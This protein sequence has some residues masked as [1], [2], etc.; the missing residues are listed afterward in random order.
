MLRV[1][2][3]VTLGV[4]GRDSPEP[5]V[6]LRVYLALSKPGDGEAGRK[7]PS[8]PSGLGTREAREKDVWLVT[9]SVVNP[10]L[11]GLEEVLAGREGSP[12]TAA[13]PACLGGPCRPQDLAPASEKAAGL[14][15]E[16]HGFLEMHISTFVT[17]LSAN[18][19]GGQEARDGSSYSWWN[20]LLVKYEKCL[21]N[22][23]PAMVWKQMLDSS[24]FFFLF[25]PLTQF[26]K[27]RARIRQTG[28]LEAQLLTC[29][30][31]P[32]MT[33]R[34]R[35]PLSRLQELQEPPFTI[36]FYIK[37]NQGPVERE[38]DVQDHV[39]WPGFP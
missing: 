19:R 16:K 25:S 33:S 7:C 8:S 38:Q 2:S 17:V 10:C 26:R 24:S 4:S 14:A 36:R 3:Q 13:W 12:R 30:K 21:R 39:A 6:G 31:G 1:L 27:K 5:L 37:G 15:W 29:V 32:G 34:V 18:C 28:Q 20:A 23:F 11:L 22:E 9:M 35:F